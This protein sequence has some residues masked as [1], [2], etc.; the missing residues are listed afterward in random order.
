MNKNQQEVIIN[1]NDIGP[2]IYL[3][4]LNNEKFSN[5]QKIIIVK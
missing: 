1:V 5:T 3:L 4:I 2:G